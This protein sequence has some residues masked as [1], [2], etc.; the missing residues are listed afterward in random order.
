MTLNYCG[1]QMMISWY[2]NGG[3]C[4]GFVTNG[5]DG[6]LE[7]KFICFC[8]RPEGVRMNSQ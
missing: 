1:Q 5:H 2:G 8:L 3:S 7:V 6:N 4:I